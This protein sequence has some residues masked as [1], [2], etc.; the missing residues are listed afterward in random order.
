MGENYRAIK[1]RYDDLTFGVLPED[2]FRD[3]RALLEYVETLR[4]ELEYWRAGAEPSD[5]PV[6]IEI[7]DAKPAH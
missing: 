6:E 4:R 3:I 2:M 1:R 5:A 7:L